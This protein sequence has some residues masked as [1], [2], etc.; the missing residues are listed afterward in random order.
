ML[1][2]TC[3]RQESRL[4]RNNLQIALRDKVRK[5]NG[6]LGETRM[7]RRILAAGTVALAIAGAG[8]TQEKSGAAQKA[9]TPEAFLELRNVQDPQFSPDGT[10]VAFVVS[11]FGSGEKRTRHIWI[12]EKEK[13]A[14]RQLTYSTKSES[15][16][17]DCLLTGKNCYFCRIAMATSNRF[18]Y[19]EWKAARRR[20]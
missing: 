13:N 6:S 18:T 1:G 12:Y 9:L 4:E 2:L 19:C 7:M 14:S 20:N 15:A 17:A 11:G 10:K 3:R 8:N 5:R 16:P